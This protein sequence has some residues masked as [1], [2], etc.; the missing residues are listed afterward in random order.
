MATNSAPPSYYSTI[1][2]KHLVMSDEAFYDLISILDSAYN[3]YGPLAG[4]KVVKEKRPG[5][6]DT[7][8]FARFV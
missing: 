6:R 8:A 5:L 4:V 3:R 7:I 1:R 2:I